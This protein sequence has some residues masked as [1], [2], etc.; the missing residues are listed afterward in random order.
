MLFP[1]LCLVA[2]TGMAISLLLLLACSSFAV[3]KII[4]VHQQYINEPVKKSQSQFQRNEAVYA[5][6]TLATT[7]W[8]TLLIIYHIWSITRRSIQA[9][10]MKGAYRHIIE[11]LVE[12]SVLYSIS[13]VV[14]IAF[15]A[16]DNGLAYYSDSI[17][18]IARV[19]IS[20][21][22]FKLT[23]LKH[24]TCRALLQ[25]F[26]LNVLLLVMPAQM[27]LKR[28]ASHHPFTLNHI[29]VTR[30]N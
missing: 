28:K 9:E 18:T 20:Y 17:V 1:T 19:C 30:L 16:T 7:L 5:S 15:F 24:F 21:F 6:F 13:L 22:L 3:F 14:F 10:G 2:G 12:S 8:C 27:M 4:D 23:Y 26:F 11:V 25:H 29:Q